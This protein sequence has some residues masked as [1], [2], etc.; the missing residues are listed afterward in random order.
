MRKIVQG[1]YLTETMFARATFLPSFAYNLAR[2]RLQVKLTPWNWFDRI[3]EN[4]VLGALPL[5]GPIVQK[6]SWLFR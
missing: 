2:N 4:V 6:V 3:D 1:K 5:K